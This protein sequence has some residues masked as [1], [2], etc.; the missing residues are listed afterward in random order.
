S[1]MVTPFFLWKDGSERADQLWQEQDFEIFG[2]DGSLQTQ[3]MTPGSNDQ[4][5]TEHV[6]NHWLPQAAFERYYTYRMEWTPTRL[7]FYIDGNLMREETDPNEYWKFL[8]QSKSE[9]AQLRI[10]LW[11]GDYAWSG[12]FD[13]SA[14][15]G[16]VFVNWVQTYSY[17][18]GKGPNQS[19]FSPLW[20]DDFNSL[21][22]NRWWTANWTFEFAI[23]DYVPQNAAA[24]SGYLV[25]AFTDENKTGVFPSP[26]ADDGTV[27]KFEANSGGGSSTPPTPGG[28]F[29][30]PARIEAEAYQAYYDTSLGNSGNAPCVSGDVDAE[31]TSDPN[32]GVCNIAW[33]DAGEWLE[34]DVNVAQASTYELIVRAASEEV[35]QTVHVEVDGVDVSGP[36]TSPAQ[37]WQAFADVRVPQVALSAG[38][39]TVRLVFD[40]GMVN[41]NYLEFLSA[42]A[43]TVT[44]PDPGSSGSG[45]TGGTSSSG[46]TGSTNTSSGGTHAGTG[47]ALNGG[48]GGAPGSSGANTCTPTRTTYEAESLPATTGG[49]SPGGWNLWSNGSLAASHRFGGASSVIR[50]NAYGQAAVGVA[51]HM[52]VSVGGQTIGDVSVQA[53]SYSPYEFFYQ[54]GAGTREV[55]V[56]FDND[57]YQNGADRNLYVDSIVID[58]CPN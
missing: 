30:L 55:K 34:Y 45:S 51:P 6:V 29:T 38:L 27:L 9:A 13:S 18:P 32:G 25:L 40:T 54:P 12:A 43:N 17:T 24:K 36:L 52:I 21:D 53:T 46:G 31:G 5:R 20:R 50:V 4:H 22:S 15:P 26:P 14:A 41:V 11:A 57:Y 8:D 58:E 19:D 23:N 10:S 28:P 35:G 37:G 2:R 56:S 7:A 48:A 49:G 3:L 1:G 39:H 33:T 16:A 47:G 44:P 42:Q